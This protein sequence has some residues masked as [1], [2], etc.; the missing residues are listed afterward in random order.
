MSLARFVAAVSFPILFLS[1]QTPAGVIQ[2]D[3]QAGAA[4]SKIFRIGLRNINLRGSAA[5]GRALERHIATAEKTAGKQGGK[6]S[7][8]Y[9]RKVMRLLA[10]D[11]GTVDRVISN[12]RR[13]LV[14]NYAQ[15]RGFRG[16]VLEYLRTP[17]G[18]RSQDVD[19]V[20]DE[21]EGLGRERISN[22]TR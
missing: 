2:T 5:S 9:M 4:A 6:V 21:L 15:L 14:G 12:E 8:A 22:P 11:L 17:A 3:E 1:C 18:I 7:I 20:S 19:A 13:Q 16:V 10:D